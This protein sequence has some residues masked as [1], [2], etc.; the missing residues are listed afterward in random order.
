MKNRMKNRLIACALLLAVPAL[1]AERPE[2]TAL[3][4]RL[5]AL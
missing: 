5:V 2:V 1:A 4:Q 3:N